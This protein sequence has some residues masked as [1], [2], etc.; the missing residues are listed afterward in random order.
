[1]VLAAA[2]DHALLDRQAG[3]R[4][5]QRRRRELEQSRP[6]SRRRAR[7]FVAPIASKVELLP[8]AN[9]E[10]ETLVSIWAAFTCAISRPSSSAAIMRSA[11]GEP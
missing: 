9:A 5:T 11:V 6:R 3:H 2:G 7:A 10:I 1:M 8:A 4:N